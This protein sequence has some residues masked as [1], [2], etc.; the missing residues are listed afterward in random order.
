MYWAMEYLMGVSVTL[1]VNHRVLPILHGPLGIQK[2][3]GSGLCPSVPVEYWRLY[4][5]VKVQ[6]EY[7]AELHF[8][9]FWLLVHRRLIPKTPVPG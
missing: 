1:E 9:G 8:L 2:E 4:A 5:K 3:Q 6:R 7:E